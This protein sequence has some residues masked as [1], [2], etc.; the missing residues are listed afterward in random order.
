MASMQ[1]ASVRS[2]L[3][4]S[5]AAVGGLLLL[6]ARRRSHGSF[7]SMIQ[8]MRS[9]FN[10]RLHA[11][12]HVPIELESSTSRGAA[13]HAG[14]IVRDGFFMKREVENRF[15]NELAFL[16]RLREGDTMTLFAPEFCG[17]EI[18]EGTRYLKML[19]F[20]Q[21]FEQASLRQMDVKMGVR[22]FAEK[23]LQSRK[24]RHDLYKRLCKMDASMLTEEENAQQSITKARWM[25]LRDSM[26]S[27]QTHGFR[28]DGVVTPTLRREA[29]GDLATVREDADIIKV[30]QC[31]LP[32]GHEV[33][34]RVCRQL[35]ARLASLEAALRESSLFWASELIGS[36]LLFAADGTGRCCVW[37]LDFGLTCHAPNGPLKHDI[38]WQLGN[39][40]DGYLL[41]LKN[42]RRL[43]ETIL[44]ED[45]WP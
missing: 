15:E 25:A 26:S 20:L 41:G 10:R 36:S 3:L 30:L 5:L 11:C 16:Q 27:T 32:P 9:Y 1:V 18:I 8:A 37:M 33:A 38:E 43:W 4:L 29:F 42:L 39:H 21:A 35:L 45:Q 14:N 40:E 6:R 44:R 2:S 12:P 22:C 34:R 23:E 28:V 24:P 31:F 7:A 13:G 19:D 17:V